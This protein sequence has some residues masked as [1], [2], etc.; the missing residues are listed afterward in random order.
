M[1]GI[2]NSHAI[3]EIPT[4]L[5][6][7]QSTHLRIPNPN[8]TTFSICIQD[9]P[10]T[11]G[12]RTAFTNPKILGEIDHSSKTAFGVPLKANVDD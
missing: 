11:S 4:D 5:N 3:T 12:R 10:A 7:R 9:R 6:P 8:P 2:C 1:H